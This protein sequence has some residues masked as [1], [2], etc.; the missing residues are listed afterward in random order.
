MYRHCMQQRRH[1]LFHTGLCRCCNKTTPPDL[2]PAISRLHGMDTVYDDPTTDGSGSGMHTGFYSRSDSLNVVRTVATAMEQSE[3]SFYG[4][5]LEKGKELSGPRCVRRKALQL[6]DTVL[7]SI[8]MLAYSLLQHPLSA[9]DERAS[10]VTHSYVERREVW[11][12]RRS[13]RDARR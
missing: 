2:F 3:L 10:D 7:N 13:Q 11:V 6:I 1:A 9:F 5:L 4:L 8:N 12:R